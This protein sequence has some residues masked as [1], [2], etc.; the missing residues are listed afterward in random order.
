M[1]VQNQT[2]GH[3]MIRLLTSYIPIRVGLRR[4]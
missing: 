4:G 2:L 3:A 1:A